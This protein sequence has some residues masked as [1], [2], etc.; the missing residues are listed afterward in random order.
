MALRTRMKSVVSA[1]CLIYERFSV[2]KKRTCPKC[3]KPTLYRWKLFGDALIRY[4]PVFCHSCWSSIGFKY[5]EN[6]DG[7][8]GLLSMMF[9]EWVLAACVVVGLLFFQSIWVGAG[10]FVATRLLKAWLVY[11][12][13]LE[14]VLEQGHS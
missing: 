7:F 6:T 1:C 14:V 8:R 10:I 2:V 9:S 13:P 11:C 12:G 5:A 3:E 4:R